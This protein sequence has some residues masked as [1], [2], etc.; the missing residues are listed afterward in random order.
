MFHQKRTVAEDARHEHARQIAWD[1]IRRLLD[2]PATV[3][4]GLEALGQLLAVRVVHAAVGRVARRQRV[5]EA[6]DAE[7][8]LRLPAVHVAVV[9]AVVVVGPP[10]VR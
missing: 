3:P 2:D 10:I 9:V 1:A 5:A 4:G 7:G 8:F 6:Q